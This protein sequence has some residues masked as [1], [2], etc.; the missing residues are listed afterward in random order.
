MLTTDDGRRTDDGYLYILTGDRRQT[1]QFC[2]LDADCL[3]VGESQS[4]S[5]RSAGKYPVK[6]PRPEGDSQT[7]DTPVQELLN[8]FFNN[9]YFLLASPAGCEPAREEVL[10]SQKPNA[11]PT[12]LSGRP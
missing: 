12:E 5:R 3:V 4:S 8:R 2:F 9:R 6:P 1:K 11:L 7:I 10:A